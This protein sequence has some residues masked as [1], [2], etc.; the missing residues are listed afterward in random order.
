MYHLHLARNLRSLVFLLIA[1]V[2]VAVPGTLWWANRTG[3]PES[4]RIAI[5]REISKQGAHVKIG[6]LSYHPLRGIVASRVQ[7]FSDPGLQHEISRLERVVLDF[8]KTKL[9]RGNFH[10]TRIELNDAALLLPVDP[11]EPESEVLEINH[12]NGTLFIPGGRRIEIRN[13]TGR[14]AGIEVSLDARL[15]GYQ[16]EGENPPDESH[17]RKRRE[18]LARI[19]G[20]LKKWHFDQNSPPRLRIHVD[21]DANDPSSVVAKVSLLARGVEKNQY[22]LNEISAEAEISGDLLTIT[23]LKAR[24]SR[25][26]LDGS[27]DYDISERGGR[28]DLRSSLE[29]PPLLEDWLGVPPLQGIVLGGGQN[30]DA[31]GE[32]RIDEHNVPKVRMTGRARLESVQ[33]RGVP[34]DSLQTSFSW[35]DGD[36]FLRDARLS[37]RDGEATGKAMIQWPQVRLALESTL[38]EQLLKPFFIGQPLEIVIGDFTDR[39]GAH[40]H[41]KLEGS[42]DASDRFSWAYTGSGSVENVSYKGVPVNHADC[43]FSLS[44]HELDFYDGTVIFNYRNYPMRQDFNGPAEATAK[45]GRIRYDAPSKTVEVENV[46]GSIWAA[47]LVRLFAPKIA[48]SLEVY[49]F[50]EPPELRGSGVVDV[51]PQ[52]RTA[53][54]VSFKSGG[55]ADYRFLGENLML[56]QPSGNVAIRGERV[57]IGDLKLNAFNGPVAAHFDFRGHG[58]L[59]GE[60]SWTHLSI[61]ELTST[62]GFQMKGGGE[63]TG[64]LEFSLTDGKVETMNGEGLFALEKTELFAV[65]MFGPL[66]S[67][68]SGVLGDRRV[69]FERAKNAF[70]TFR[71]KDGILSTRDFRTATPSLVFAGDGAVDL[72][73]RT[74]DM[75]MR[76]N[77]RGLLGLITLPLRPFYGMFQFRGTGPLKDTKWENVMFTSPDEAQKELLQ[78]APKARVVDGVE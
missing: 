46:A 29:I 63:V 57:T 12:A 68:I 72:R 27:A 9:A 55:A 4:W 25:G 48:D 31:E 65:P 21:G 40:V 37:R 53:L 38:P 17:T 66:S 76:M 78:P 33:L 32:F 13:A 39:K 61:P 15:I 75:T 11:K 47:P 19:I 35:R 22:T 49:R 8:D 34:F 28:F 54:D 70:C 30:L 41:V 59:E 14:I 71:I 50:H 2:I 74:L 51:T 3:L 62:Y 44:H 16:Q 24:D 10:L 56:S 69:G 58:K 5:E 18:L 26:S 43:K 36:L 45:V 23:S 73:D 77:A 6:S 64:R 60:M 1:A 52:G 42:F 67:V 20:E 7:I